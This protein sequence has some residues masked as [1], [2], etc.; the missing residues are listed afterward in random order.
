MVDILQLVPANKQAR[1]NGF[2]VAAL[3]NAE[4]LATRV[5]R[6]DL[7]TPVKAD[8]AMKLDRL[9]CRL[10]MKSD[11]IRALFE[12]GH[13]T[14]VAWMCWSSFFFSLVGLFETL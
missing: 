5:R 13:F 9:T 8:W 12:A 7:R 1:P 10:E 14:V 2:S 6:G 11:L 4:M 3:C